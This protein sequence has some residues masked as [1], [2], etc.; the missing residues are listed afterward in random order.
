MLGEFAAIL[1]PI[2][3]GFVSYMTGSPRLSILSVILLFAV[4]AVLLA[5]VEVHPAGTAAETRS[6][7]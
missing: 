4:G 3:I 1:G 7:D 5:S 2:M 6:P